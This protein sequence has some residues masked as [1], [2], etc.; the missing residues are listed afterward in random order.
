MNDVDEAECPDFEPSTDPLDF[1][2]PA[3]QIVRIDDYRNGHVV[4]A[5]ETNDDNDD[6]ENDGRVARWNTQ[7]PSVEAALRQYGKSR[8]GVSGIQVSVYV[9]GVLVVD[10][11][12]AQ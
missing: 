10:K 9:D 5:V 7:H 4:A 3:Y 8:T 11:A 1:T 2:N 6:G 12:G